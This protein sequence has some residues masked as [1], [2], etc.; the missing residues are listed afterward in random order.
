M[1]LEISVNEV[2]QFYSTKGSSI[3]KDK[4]REKH[5]SNFKLQQQDA[6]QREAAASRRMQEL[7]RQFATILR[8]ANTSNFLIVLVRW[9]FYFGNKRLVI[10]FGSNELA[11]YTQK[12]KGVVIPNFLIY[13]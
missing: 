12:R 8:Q 13:S 2:E 1:Q 4:D 5:F 11:N 10:L 3:V 6:S 7:M 9:A